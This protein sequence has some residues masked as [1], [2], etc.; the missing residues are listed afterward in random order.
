MLWVAA[1]I[2]SDSPPLYGDPV[3]PHPEVGTPSKSPFSKFKPR[4]KLV[5]KVIFPNLF[6]FFFIF[7]INT[8]F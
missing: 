3:S 1:K 6:Y 5:I 2:E 8:S 7:I 4:P